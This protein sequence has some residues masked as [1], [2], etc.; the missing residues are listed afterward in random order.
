MSSNQKTSK[1]FFLKISSLIPGFKDY[2]S[3]ENLRINDYEIRKF[4]SKK[5][6]EKKE[7]FNNLKK[8]AID[9]KQ[10]DLILILDKSQSTLRNFSDKLRL[11]KHG[12]SAIFDKEDINNEKLKQ[13]IEND[14]KLLVLVDKLSET[15]ESI[16]ITNVIQSTDSIINEMKKILKSRDQLLG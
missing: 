11:S 6:D 2:N 7:T 15:D 16:D 9:Q 1:S 13:M 10:H 5:I 3:K 14:E 4:C 8:M 12:Y